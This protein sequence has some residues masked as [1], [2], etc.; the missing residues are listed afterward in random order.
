[1]FGDF[2]SPDLSVY[3]NIRRLPAATCIRLQQ[4]RFYL[5]Q[6][7]ILPLHNTIRYRKDSEYVDRFQEVFGEAVN[8]RLRA[9]LV[10][11]E[12]SGGMDSSSIAAITKSAGCLIAAHTGT[13]HDLLSDDQEGYYADMV[14]SYLNIPIFYQ[15]CDSYALFDRFDDPQLNTSEPYSSPDKAVHYDR[16]HQIINNGTRVLM[17]G[18]GG[19]ALFM[20]PST[21]YVQLLLSGRIVRLLTDVY[22]RVRS[23]G[24]LRGMGLRSALMRWRGQ[25]PLHPVFPD[26]VD[27][28]FAKRTQLKERWE[29]NW[30][31]IHRADTGGTYFQLCAPW[32]SSVFEGYEKLKMP[33]VAR[34]PFFDVRLVMFMLSVPNH[35]KLGKWV[36]RDAMRGRLPEPVR[37]RP[38]GGSTGDL[39]RTKLAEGQVRISLESGLSRVGNVYID[40]ARY[41][42]FFQSYV[43]G[44]GAQSVWS[45][46]HMISP[47]ALNNWLIQHTL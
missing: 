35:I 41:G 36:M 42:E 23:T 43:G 34:H 25:E 27:A 7:W 45:S 13:C 5:Q 39:V 31:A 14:A 15:A 28:E 37:K 12:L 22:R 3:R 10:A 2:Q 1:M 19:D 46:Y 40:A 47:I 32:I 21:Y 9:N 26:W 8:D 20:E 29:L 30:R 44:E 17:T 11:I 38:K 24:S 6:Y 4:D 16:L 33:L 18:Q